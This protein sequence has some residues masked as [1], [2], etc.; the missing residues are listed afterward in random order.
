MW[1]DYERVEELGLEHYLHGDCDDWVLENFKDGDIA[2]IWNEYNYEVNKVVLIHCYIKR[3]NLF[4]DVRGE[5]TDEELIED[6]YDYGYDNGK[7]YCNSIE[8]YKMWIRKIC[9]YRSKKWQ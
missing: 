9:R 7:V 5:T 4:V 6:G 8:E 1:M 2:I 3:G